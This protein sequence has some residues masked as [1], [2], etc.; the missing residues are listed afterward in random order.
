MKKRMRLGGA[1]LG[2]MLS[3]AGCSSPEP[4]LSAAELTKKYPQESYVQLNGVSL[5]YEQQ[6][7]GRPLVLLHGFLT[8]SHLWRN[9]VPGLTYGSTIYN[10]DLMGFGLSEKPQNQTYNLDTYVAQLGK[11]L[12]DFH[13][14]QPVLVGHDASAV[15]ATLYAIR[16]PGKVHKLILINAPL[17]PV[18]LPPSLRLLRTRLIGDLFTGDWFLKRILRGGVIDPAKMPDILLKEY[19]TPYHDDPGARTAL[20]KFVREFDLRP[21]LENEIQPNLAKLQLP[22]MLL[23]GGQNTYVPI[24]IGSQLE[25]AIPGSVFSVVHTTGHYIQEERPEEMRA[26]IKE[27]I[28]K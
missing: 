28:D 7:L 12:E 4:S 25:Q 1:V 13:L 6:G 22:I 17:Q 2:I 18:T 26:R 16:N 8:Y 14:E 9:V 21:V 23:W 3:L 20:L 10:L 15:I 11:F 5:H 27:F 19:L 24:E